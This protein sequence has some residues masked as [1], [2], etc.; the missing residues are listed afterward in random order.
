METEFEVRPYHP[1]DMISLYDIC[2]PIKD[3]FNNHNQIIINRQIWGHFWVAPFV[4]LEPHLCFVLTI[5]KKPVGYIIATSD[6]KKFLMKSENDWFP[7]LRNRF[8]QNN[9]SEFSPQIN[10][11]KNIREGYKPFISTMES[12]GMFILRTIPLSD[13]AETKSLLLEKLFEQFKTMGI[14]KMFTVID[15]NN[16]RDFKFLENL[17]FHKHVEINNSIILAKKLF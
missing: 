17:S 1:S 13:F 7:I 2:C 16:Q 9:F 5:S 15:I 6:I 10:I 4:I 8:I 11:L 14:N 12:G 3:Q